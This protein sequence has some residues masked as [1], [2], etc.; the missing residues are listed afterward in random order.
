MSPRYHSNRLLV[1]DHG[2]TRFCDMGYCNQPNA[3]SCDPTNQHCL[4][5]PNYSGTYCENQQ[6]KHW[7][8]TTT[9]FLNES[10]EFLI[11][12]HCLETSQSSLLDNIPL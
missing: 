2:T 9:T 5:N 12:I 1:A 7:F 11:S 10:Y 8:Y 3:H 4:C 6:C